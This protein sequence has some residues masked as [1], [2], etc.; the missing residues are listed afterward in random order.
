MKWYKKIINFFKDNPEALMGGVSATMMNI[1]FGFHTTIGIL[2]IIGFCII[3]I[4]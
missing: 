2:G 3:L 1:G 4:R